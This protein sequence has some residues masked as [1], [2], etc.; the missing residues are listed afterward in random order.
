MKKFKFFMDIEQEEQ[1]L[2]DMAQRGFVFKAKNILS[3]YIFNKTADIPQIRLDY[4][5]FNRKSDF[6]DYVT[7]FEDSGW[8]HVQGTK[9]SGTQYFVRDKTDAQEDIFSD[10]A[11][12]A[13]RYKRH[14]E[15][16]GLLTIMFSAMFI[17]IWSKT[18]EVESILN[19]KGLYLT[20]GLWDKAGAEF[21][22]A[23]LFE[24]PFALMR[25][26]SWLFIIGFVL[27]STYLSVKSYL[28]YRQCRQG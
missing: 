15:N 4:R 11:S 26:F 16:W 5:P 18:I 20:P 17:A 7:L 28:R 14:S 13:G 19:P 3:Q 23:F 24:T 9:N 8:K 27:L 12:R 25:G 2:N 21:W 6:L 22:G 1:W 10:Q